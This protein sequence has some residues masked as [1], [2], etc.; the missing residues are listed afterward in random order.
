MLDREHNQRWRDSSVLERTVF[1]TLYRLVFEV[2]IVSLGHVRI[3]MYYGIG[4]FG[5]MEGVRGVWGFLDEARLVS[6]R[7][8]R[9]QASPAAYCLLL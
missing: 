1:T 9:P 2:K 5:K 7:A 4:M 8:F 6:E 3:G